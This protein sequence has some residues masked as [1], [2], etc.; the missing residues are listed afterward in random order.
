MTHWQNTIDLLEVCLGRLSGQSPLESVHCLRDYLPKPWESYHRLIL[1]ELIKFD[2]AA[3]AKQ[4]I[5]RRLADYLSEF[6]IELPDSAVPLDLVLEELQI[7]FESSAKISLDPDLSRFSH[8]AEPLKDWQ[9]ARALPNDSVQPIAPKLR[10]V[11]ELKIGDLIEDFRILRCVGRGGFARVY[12]ALQETLQRLVA[13]KVSQRSGEESQTLSQLDHPN[14]VR[15]YDER[16][17]S[18]PPVRLLYMQFVGGGTMQD[19]LK[20]LDAVPMKERRG[21]DLMS[22]IAHHL[23]LCGLESSTQSESVGVLGQLDWP[24]TVAWVGSQLSE[25]LDYAHKN[26]VIHRDIKPANILFAADGTPKLVDF[27]VSFSGIAGRAGAAAFFGGSLA[28]MSPEQIEISLSIDGERSAEELDYRSDL[29]SLGIVLWE[30]LYGSRPWTHS[31]RPDSWTDALSNELESRKLSVNAQVNSKESDQSPALRVLEH[32][33][34]ACLSLDPCRR[35]ASGRQLTDMLRL[36][37]FPKAARRV[38]PH[39]NRVMQTLSKLPPWLLLSL[40]GLLPN[41]AAAI[42]NFLYNSSQIVENYPDL[43]NAFFLLSTCVNL[44]F[45]PLGVG[46]VIYLIVKHSGS[47][48][49]NPVGRQGAARPIYPKPKLRPDSKHAFFDP[50]PDVSAEFP[51]TASNLSEL[52]SIRSSIHIETVTGVQGK[53]LTQV[54][55]TPAELPLEPAK[56]EKPAAPLEETTE[57]STARTQALPL[58]KEFAWNLGHQVAL[59]CGGLWLLAGFIFP[60]LLL[61]THPLF[62]WADALHFFAS[63][64][65]CGAVA[66][67]Y[68]F[69]WITCLNLTL[70]YPMTI[71]QTLH[72][73]SILV[74]GPRLRR[75]SRGYLITA[76]AIPL[77]ALLLLVTAVEVPRPYLVATILT[78]AAGFAASLFA[79]QFID[80]YVLDLE[81]AMRPPG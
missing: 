15:V 64:T 70:Y 47:L 67:V 63:L 55:G 11:P 13:L 43:W 57:P 51:Q 65:I 33:L 27:N 5:D 42:F 28:Y 77:I 79:V 58:P 19:C 45:F 6:A 3:A 69:Y 12:L 50:Q 62:R 17:P 73:S 4:G 34:Q 46:W 25:G 2:L 9:R 30:M 68:P 16:N 36:A 8:L 26:Q 20:R 1:I 39:H 54:Q 37:L 24:S 40:G 7:L 48:T 81:P 76:A 60:V 74:W 53:P 61:S 41:A 80:D 22:S 52:E 29:Y 21:A 78:T 38:L 10:Q 72:D 56:P 31:R 66:M 59:V 23:E 35:P 18:D 71:R 32:S 75:L 14:I 44:I 49:T